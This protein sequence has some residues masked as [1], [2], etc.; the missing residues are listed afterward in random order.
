VSRSGWIDH[1]TGPDLRVVDLTAPLRASTP[2]FPADPPFELNW[3]MTYADC[4]CNLSVIRTGL[5]A[6][7]HVDAPLHFIDGGTDVASMPV[8]PFLGDAVAIDTPKEPGEDVVPDDLADADI[9]PG[10]IVLVRTGWE[11]RAGTP[12]F[13]QDDWPGFSVEAID[14][15]V[16]LGVKAIGGDITSADSPMGLWRGARAHHRALAAGLPIFEALVNLHEVVGRRFLFVGLPLN[17]DG[18]EASPVRAIA[19]LLPEVRE[20]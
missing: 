14:A 2:V 16:A 12:E 1:F 18:A 6:G 3:H 7:T 8:T 19:I 11:A 10:D 13:L 15:L 17:I 5:H 9:R 20:A 4:G